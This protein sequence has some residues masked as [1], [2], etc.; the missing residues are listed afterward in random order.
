MKDKLSAF[1]S[2]FKDKWSSPCEKSA[3]IHNNCGIGSNSC[4]NSAC[5]SA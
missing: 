4:R 3:D 5:D 1:W 2:G